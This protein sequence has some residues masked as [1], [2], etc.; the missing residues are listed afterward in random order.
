[1]PVV[2]LTFGYLLLGESLTL[3]QLVGSSITL[4]GIYIYNRQ[5]QR[6]AQ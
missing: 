4:T 1:Q 2:T 5:N 6:A 3:W